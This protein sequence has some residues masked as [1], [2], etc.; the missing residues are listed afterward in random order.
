MVGDYASV[1]AE[2]AP[3][4]RRPLPERR[5]ARFKA[6]PMDYVFDERIDSSRRRRN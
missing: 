2:L 6:L 1:E 3:P 5:Y 4:G